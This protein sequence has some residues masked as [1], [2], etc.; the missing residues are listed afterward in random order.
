MI[1]YFFKWS[2]RLFIWHNLVWIKYSHNLAPF[3]NKGIKRYTWILNTL[4]PWKLPTI[5]IMFS[6][7]T[8]ERLEYFLLEY[9][10]ILINNLFWVF[11]KGSSII[12]VA[13]IHFFV[14]M[15]WN[16][17]FLSLQNWQNR[18]QFILQFSDCCLAIPGSNILDLAYFQ[19]CQ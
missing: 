11:P 17:F 19:N 9:I 3:Q 8:E 7:L 4:K 12:L 6:N 15:R 5:Y 2:L 10:E 14:A 16:M 1:R 13:P 18:H